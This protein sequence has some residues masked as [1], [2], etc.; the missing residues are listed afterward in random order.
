MGI[1]EIRRKETDAL[2]SP[3]IQVLPSSKR[4]CRMK[5]TGFEVEDG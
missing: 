1:E 2:K 4:P 3:S 5:A